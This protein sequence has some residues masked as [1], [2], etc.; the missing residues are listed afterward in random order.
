M[1]LALNLGMERRFVLETPLMWRDKA[2]TWAL[3]FDL[4]GQGLVEVIRERTHTCYLGDR[5]TSSRLGF[6]M[7]DL[8]GLP[9]ARPGLD[10]LDAGRWSAAWLEGRTFPDGRFFR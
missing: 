2:A 7:R 5:T 3:A 9:A 6:R 8:P 1:Q 10:A 4:G